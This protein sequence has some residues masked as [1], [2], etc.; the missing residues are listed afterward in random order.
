MAL[1]PC[2]GPSALA[3]DL[4][5]RRLFSACDKVMV[6]TNADTGQSCR[7]SSDRRGS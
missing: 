7:F 3:I 5:N 2:E 1:A 6:V 4:K